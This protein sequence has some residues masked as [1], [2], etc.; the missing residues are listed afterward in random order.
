MLKENYTRLIWNSLLENWDRTVFTNYESVSYTYGEVGRSI[1]YLHKLFCKC[2]LKKGDKI[3]LIGKN[4]AEWAIAYQA[5]VTFGAVVVPIMPNFTP[6]D[7]Q[8]IINHSDSEMM[9][10]NKAN[11]DVLD[12]EN[13]PN[14]KSVI[15]LDDFSPLYTANKHTDEHINKF[16]SLL[17]KPF[18]KKKLP[19]QIIP[20]RELFA[21]IYTS[22]TTGFSKGVMLTH[23][24]ITGNMVYARTYMPLVP[25]DHI[26]SF[27]PLAHAYGCAIE[28]L[29]PFT[30]GCHITFLGKMPTPQLLLKAFAEIKPR[31]ILSVPLII[32]KIFKKQIKPVLDQTKIKFLMKIPFMDSVILGKIKTK[33]TESFGGNFHEIV[34]GGA[35]I[36]EEVQEVFRKAGFAFTIGYGMTECGPLISYASWREA[37]FNSAGRCVDQLEM[38]IDSPDPENVVGEILVRGENVM[39][40][41]YK[42]VKATREI[43][44]RDGWLH[45]GD[46]GTMDS[47][48]FLYI[49]GRSKSMILGPSGQNIYPEELEARINAFPL[50]QESLVVDR[51]EGLVA[52][53]YPDMEM[54]DDKK[55]KEHSLEV[56]ME[57]YCKQLNREIA[58]YMHVSRFQIVSSE[59]EK[60]PKR[61]IKRFLYS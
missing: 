2:G 54:V 39:K 32:E 18:D 3:A 9:F 34:V 17:D 30:S 21:I 55:M 24:N 56:I 22:G 28:F 61:S 8:H 46:L 23:N 11:W 40:G 25:G 14:L 12:Q 27:L 58:N 47:D 57:T 43:I 44:D 59:F 33:L 4:C 26:L 52:L 53:I 50:V 37:R 13:L 5:I 6:N 15:S 38:R 49:K 36:N 16:K 35:A 45:T 42:N 41:Y 19:N 31:L 20:N 60:T 29:Y 10:A 48:G 1:Y 7:V 51:K